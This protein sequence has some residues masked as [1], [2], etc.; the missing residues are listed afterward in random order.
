MDIRCR[1]RCRGHDQQSDDEMPMTSKK[2][3]KKKVKRD[4]AKNHVSYGL[5]GKN[6]GC[7]QAER[8]KASLSFGVRDPGVSGPDRTV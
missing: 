4:R 5:A 1:P 6:G 3:A 2:R 7:E 8:A